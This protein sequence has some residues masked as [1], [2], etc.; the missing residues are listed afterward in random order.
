VPALETLTQYE[1]VKLFEQN[2]TKIKIIFMDCMMPVMDGIEF[3]KF[4]K[5]DFETSHIPFILLTAKDALESRL[6]GVESGADYYFSKPVSTN[7]LLL[8]LRNQLKQQ[9]KIK[10]R[11]LKDYQ[12]EVRDLVHSTKD[13]DFMDQLLKIIDDKL[14]DQ[15]L[16]IDYVSKEIGVSQSKLY[17]KIKDITGQSSNEFIRTIR[18]K[19]SME[20]MTREDVSISEVMYRVGISSNSYFTTAFKKEFGIT[21]SKFQQQLDNKS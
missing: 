18:L 11:Y 2:S 21:P 8:T 14:E 9:Q 10:E 7:L 6:Q 13:K 12:V 5:D 3:C 15:E 16:N 19:K 4:V 20:I 17:K 1:A